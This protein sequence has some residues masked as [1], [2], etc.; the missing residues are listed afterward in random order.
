LLTTQNQ[1]KV[2]QKE[3]DTFFNYLK[4]HSKDRDIGFEGIELRCTNNTF[5]SKEAAHADTLQ[6]K[7]GKQQP[8]STPHRHN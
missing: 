3:L 6:C 4:Q 8:D 5:T 2:A 7:Y 1:I